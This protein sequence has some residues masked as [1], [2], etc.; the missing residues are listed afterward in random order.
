MRNERDKL[1]SILIITPSFE[2]GGAEKY[3]LMLIEELIKRGKKVVFISSG[4][5]LESKL[6]E[7]VHFIKMPV[8]DK[9]IKN[10]FG[11][12][13][14]IRKVVKEHNVQMIHSQSIY[15]TIISKLLL[16]SKP[17]M[18][19]IHGL[20]EE[21]Y[22]KANVLMKI[23]A[24]KVIAVSGKTKESMSRPINVGKKLDVIYNGIEIPNAYKANKEENIIKIG[25]V[26]RLHPDK[27]H[28]LLLESFRELLQRHSDLFL[29]VVG[30]GEER[31]RLETY[32]RENSIENKVLFTGF[33]ENVGEYIKELDIMVLPSYRE[34]LPL[35]ILEGM[36]YG[37]CVVASNVGGI[38]E[39]IKDRETGLLCKPGNQEDLVN[40][41]E[42]VIVDREMRI[43]LGNQA[44]QCAKGTFS[45]EIFYEK[46]LE[47]YNSILK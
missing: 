36:S 18:V 25:V 39:A 38:P 6:N 23:F 42:E 47:A 5:A 13:I 44:Y 20:K 33:Q 40:K 27:G 15:T 41:L 7:K 8:L 37:K 12:A 14:K 16:P 19:T 29:Y 4:G 28:L 34:G 10:I 17:V 26:A 31:S 24:D 45:N 35:S 2:I 43:N 11:L 22:P 3:V 9:S 46:M 21:D 32:V 1:E 30:D